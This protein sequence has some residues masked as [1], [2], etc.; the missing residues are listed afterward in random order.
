MRPLALLSRDAVA[1]SQLNKR[2]RGRAVRP[3]SWCY[4]STVPNP[5]LLSFAPEVEGS[6]AKGIRSQRLV[7]VAEG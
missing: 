2:D 4:G 1:P 6:Q 5:L 3:I 7:K